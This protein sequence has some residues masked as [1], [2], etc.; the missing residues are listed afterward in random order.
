[1][2]I[3][4][5][6]TWETSTTQNLG[7]DVLFLNNRLALNADAYIRKTTDMFTPGV[8][9]PA[10][11][12]AATPRGNYADME[13]KGWEISLSWNDRLDLAA[14]PFN[15]HIKATVSDNIS[16]ILRYNNPDKRL[17]DYYPG[18]RL[19][20]IWG[21]VTD[22]FFRSEEQVRNS[23]D[24]SLFSSTATGVWRPGDIKFTDVNNDG[25][26]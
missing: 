1:N 2:V 12:G 13:T 11:F 24:Q 6:L 3:P 18:Q 4:Y 16:T 20:E 15:Y 17:N 26:I 9:L 21:Y 14:K 5:G 8:E 25:V 7:L 10:V 22:G 23:A 19:G